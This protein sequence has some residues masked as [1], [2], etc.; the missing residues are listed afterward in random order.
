M[1]DK[2]F[3]SRREFV[4]TT[5]AAAAGAVMG[6]VTGAP[7][8]A[9]LKSPNDTVGVGLIGVGV[10]G[11]Q[12]LGDVL[13]VPNV[14]I[15]AICDVYDGHTQRAVK[16]CQ[17]EKV[18][19]TKDYRRVLDSKDID[20]VVIA[21]PDHWHSEMTVDAAAAGKD[22]YVEKCMTRTIPEAK[23]IVKAI[24]SNRR[25]LQLGHQGRSNPI[26]KRAKE[27]VDAGELGKI[28]LV[29]T[30]TY[31]NGDQPQWRW[32]SSYSN[33]QLPADATPEH[34]DWE[35]FLGRAPKRP[36]SVRRFFHWRCYWDYGTGI[37]G[38]LLTHQMDGVNSVLKMGI[39]HSCVA[40]GNIAY[41]KDDREVPDHWHAIYEYPDR[42][43]TITYSC[44]FNNQRYGLGIN[45]LGKDG[46][47]EISSGLR[48]YA[49]PG[50][51]KYKELAEKIKKENAESKAA[52]GT[53]A[54]RPVY[55]VRPSDV[56]TQSSHMENFIEC[57]RTRGRT[58]CNEDDGFEEAVTAIM[59]VIAY[60]QKRQVFWDP[61]R[62]EVV[63]EEPAARKM[64]TK[65]QS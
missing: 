20:V 16:A 33:F 61:A 13:K 63:F 2:N 54:D 29:Q 14:Q 31:R 51:A 30:Y 53:P 38:D 4:K 15:R 11:I 36:F 7:A 50:T 10:R 65:S 56:P 35:R 18:Q 64:A 49:E 40:A 22:M 25:V 60:Q 26:Y 62:Q 47:M 24:K 41:W 3:W 5:A 37:A 48:F 46:T 17:N 58:R 28:T 42:D 19:T 21:T 23:A 39:P 6:N 43:L 27:I 34:I 12:L 45:L 9:G 32:Y 55:A 44:E 59:S 8:P 1:P 52:A 57:A